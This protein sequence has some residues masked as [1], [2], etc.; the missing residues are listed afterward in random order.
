[1][2]LCGKCLLWVHEDLSSDSENPYNNTHICYP[3]PPMTRCEM[4][5]E[6]LK[7]YVQLAWQSQQQNNDDDDGD[8][9]DDNEEE[10]KK[11]ISN[12]NAKTNKHSSLAYDS[13]PHIVITHSGQ[14]P[15]T[16]INSPDNSTKTQPLGNLMW[17]ISQLGFPFQ[18]TRLCQ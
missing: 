1:M 6:F 8:N 7:S 11:S 5:T 13:Q 12:K 15:P 9:D 10:N 14:G 4:K 18:A 3:N 16:S 17:V 2:F